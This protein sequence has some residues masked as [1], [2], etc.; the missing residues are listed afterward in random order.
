[1]YRPMLCMDESALSIDLYRSVLYTGLCYVW[2]CAV[3]GSVLKVNCD[4]IIGNP[5]SDDFIQSFFFFF[6]G[7]GGGGGSFFFFFFS[8]A[9]LEKLP[10]AS[11]VSFREHGV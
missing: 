2:V 11:D 10:L 7:G 4:V 1:M 8:R 5:T 9:N 6:A 3:Y